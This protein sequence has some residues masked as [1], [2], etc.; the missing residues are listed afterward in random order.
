MDIHL[1][2]NARAMYAIGTN[3]SA[4]PYFHRNPGRL[5][6]ATALGYTLYYRDAA[7]GRIPNPANKPGELRKSADQ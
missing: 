2:I 6:W 7:S 5:A 1:N 3:K 4:M